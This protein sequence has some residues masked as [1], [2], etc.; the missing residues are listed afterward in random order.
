MKT[1]LHG[2]ELGVRSFDFSP[3]DKILVAASMDNNVRLWDI[4]EA[5][6]KQML[7]G[8]ASEVISVAF[9]SDRKFVAAGGV[10]NSLRLWNV[11]RGEEVVAL[12]TDVCDR[13]RGVGFSPDGGPWQRQQWIISPKSGASSRVLRNRAARARN[14]RRSRGTK[15]A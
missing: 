15:A 10:D 5:K 9:S 6:E 11:A 8:G 3:D 14:G 13:V 7:E 2:H 12:W 4:T 1:F